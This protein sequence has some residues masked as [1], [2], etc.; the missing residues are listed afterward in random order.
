MSSQVI[1]NNFSYA[2]D[3]TAQE[4]WNM[5]EKDQNAILVDVRTDEEWKQVGVPDLSRLQKKPLLLSWRLLPVMQVNASFMSTLTKAVADKATTLL[6]LC[7]SGAR[8]AEAAKV[9]TQQGYVNCYNIG[10]GVEGIMNKNYSS[11][12]REQTNIG[13]KAA[14]LPWEQK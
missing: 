8:S 9:M 5:L 7:R 11:E 1:N 10:G 4:A 2:G 14:K 13:W 6:F 3:V 12:N